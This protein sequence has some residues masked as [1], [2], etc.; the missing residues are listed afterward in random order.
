MFYHQHR[1][2]RTRRCHRDRDGKRNANSNDAINVRLGD[3]AGGS[4]TFDNQTADS[5]ANEVRTV[6]DI[7]GK[8]F[9][10]GSRRHQHHGRK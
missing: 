6:S 10:R 2:E 1:A 8:W 5:S 7:F 4:P 3:A 9:A